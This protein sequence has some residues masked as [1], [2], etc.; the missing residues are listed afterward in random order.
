V[1]ISI[2]PLN[3]ALEIVTRNRI[4]GDAFAT[5]WGQVL[6]AIKSQFT[7]IE[8][9]NAEQ[10]AQL[11]TVNAILVEQ[12]NQLNQILAA[13]ASANLANAAL[14]S[15]NSGFPSG[16]SGPASFGVSSTSYVT[17]G[18]VALTG[19][20]AGTLRFDTTRLLVDGFSTSLTSGLLAADYRITEEPTSGGAVTT[21]LT[22]TWTASQLSGDPVDIVFPEAT[23]DAARPT[24]VNTGNVTYK[25]QVRRASGSAVLTNAMAIF[26]A[27]KAS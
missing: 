24:L 13:Q 4:A 11:A 9:V 15:I 21:C 25:L 20:T 1:A 8:A 27:A 22:G 18:T 17:I 7:A 12:A 6:A 16:T 26:R 5:Y 2:P 3:R 10:A 19:I 23:V 14:N